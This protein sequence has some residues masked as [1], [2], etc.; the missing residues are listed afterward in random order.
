[1]ASLPKGYWIGGLLLLLALTGCGGSDGGTSSFGGA[2]LQA[3]AGEDITVD[4]GAVAT[5]NG[6]GTNSDGT[7][8][9]YA[10]SQVSGP[11]VFI[12]GADTATASFEAPQVSANQTIVLQLIVT[13]SG[14]DTALDEVVVTVR[15]IPRT[16]GTVSGKVMHGLTGAELSGASVTVGNQTTASDGSGDFAV[17]IANSE[18]IPVT[19]RLDGYAELQKVA[20]LNSDRFEDYLALRML[21]ISLSTTFSPA[22]TTALVVPGTGASV[23]ITANTL[24]RG[25]GTAPVGNVTVHV[26]VI[27]PRNDP[28]VLTGDYLADTGGT[29]QNIETFGGVAVTAVDSEGTPLQLA[30]GQTAAIQIPSYPRGNSTAP[31]SLSLFSYDID[32]IAWQQGTTGTLVVGAPSYY[33]GTIGQLGTWSASV[34]YPSV[35]ITGCIKDE[36]GIPV[37]AARVTAA[38]ENYN[39]TAIAYSG[40]DGTFSVK[41]RQS[42]SVLINASNAN[43]VSNSVLVATNTGDS[44]ISQCLLLGRAQATV[45]L[46]WGSSPSDLDSHLYTPS[47][48][49]VYY[50]SKG[51]LTAAPYAALDVDDVTSFG[52]EVVTITQLAAGQ[53][54]YMVHNFSGT[55][56]PGQTGSPARVEVRVSGRTYIF[57]PPAGE[58][59]NLWWYVFDLDVAADGTATVNPVGTWHPNSPAGG[60]VIVQKR[61]SKDQYRV[62]E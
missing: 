27:D 30:A 16:S 44:A 29:L 34:A 4:E 3:R 58:G 24:V 8:T 41:A 1:M 50:V 42:S 40:V 22:V 54:K 5:L 14:G 53:Y 25:D 12:N 19:V 7:V 37:F 2:S 48:A 36:F 43:S 10:W 38:G 20:S 13:G 47:G 57:A 17:T 56:G 26:T 18:R 51:S 33:S 23:T 61:Y 32:A 62:V 28:E 45:K 52:P 39:G 21:P 31:A 55:F 15:N 35:N 9:G 6:G 49:H 11:P 46:T 60:G 59:A